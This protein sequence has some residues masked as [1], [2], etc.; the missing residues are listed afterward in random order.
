MAGLRPISLV[1]A[2]VEYF[3]FGHPSEFAGT[4][5]SGLVGVPSF[6]VSADVKV[7]GSAAFAVLYLPVPVVDVFVK[8]GAARI[9]TTSNTSVTVSA[10]YATCVIPRR[11]ANFLHLRSPQTPPPERGLTRRGR[12]AEA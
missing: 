5:P 8:L 3:D 6:P 9:Q 12:A 7:K 10:P 1:G 2:E 4:I 11:P